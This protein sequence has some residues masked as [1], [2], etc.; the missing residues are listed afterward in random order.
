MGKEGDRRELGFSSKN[1]QPSTFIQRSKNA[2]A[3]GKRN[4]KFLQA[5]PQKRT[6]GGKQ[7]S[8]FKGKALIH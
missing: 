5:P 7:T 4:A 8:Y 3:K 2:F 6:Y 1:A